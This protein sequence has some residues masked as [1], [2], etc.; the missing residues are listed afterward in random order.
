M[1]N[2]NVLCGLSYGLC[3]FTSFCLYFIWNL[4]FSL[5]T[6]VFISWSLV[7]HSS[8]EAFVWGIAVSIVIDYWLSTLTG[9]LLSCK[10]TQGYFFFPSLRTNLLVTFIQEWPSLSLPCRD[11]VITLCWVIHP[12]LL[13]LH[14]CHFP[15]F[16]Y[17]YASLSRSKCV[18]G[19]ISVGAMLP[20]WNSDSIT[21]ACW[22]VPPSSQLQWNVMLN[23][24][25]TD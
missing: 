16:F 7:Y 13:D 18:L 9:A 3:L 10:I 14:I 2:L 19:C 21:L 17:L 11:R 23:L 6:S 8:Q 12:L 20:L 1:C 24:K 15:L 5:T 4:I 22:Q 25:V